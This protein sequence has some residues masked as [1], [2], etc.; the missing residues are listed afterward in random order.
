MDSYSQNNEDSF[1]AG[2]LSGHE[3][4]T[5]LDIGANDGITLSNSRLL[6]ENDWKGLLVEPSKICLDRLWELYRYNPGIQILPFAVSDYCGEVSFWES[7]SH[8]SENDHSLIST[9]K[10]S[11]LDR[12][13]G[14]KFANHVMGF[15]NVIDVE[16]LLKK[17]KYKTFDFINIDAEGVD[18]VILQQL[19]LSDT[20]LLCIEWNS[21]PELKEK[22]E[23][24]CS[25]FG[26]TT[27]HANGENLILAK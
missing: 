14:S 11:E 16:T 2:Y 7:G 13:K 8:L 15:C 6:I 19:D 23:G 25:T 17:S 18:L 20:Q 21:L 27:I 24:Y 5:L 12:W 10:Q 22:I 26:M 1:I 3:V 9:I 4:G